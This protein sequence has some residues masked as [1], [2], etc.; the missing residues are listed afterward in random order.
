[1]CGDK[2]DNIPGVDGVGKKT[3][4]KL[5]NK[6][7][8]IDNIL[9]NRENIPNKRVQRGFEESINQIDLSRKLVS[10]DCSVDPGCS[11]EDMITKV[12]DINKLSNLFK[13]LEIHSLL[14]IIQQIRGQEQ[15]VD[16]PKVH[17]DK[18]KKDLE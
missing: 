15:E 16:T 7:G 6:Y 11:I 8:S 4:A 3:A 5:I 10:L 1:M 9:S 2:S 13:D 14:N 12:P 17:K 18:V